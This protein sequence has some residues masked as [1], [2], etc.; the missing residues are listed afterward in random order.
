MAN[1]QKENGYVSIANELQ[2]QFFRFSF[3]KRQH[4][5]LALLLRLSYGC[6][7]KNCYIPALAHF[8]ICG[9]FKQDI[10]KEID[11]LI[12]ARVITWNQE[13]MIFAINKDYEEWTIKKNDKFDGDILWDLVALQLNPDYKPG[14]KVS[15]TL[16]QK[17]PPEV[18]K[19]LTQNDEG[20]QNTYPEVSKTLTQE[21][22]KHLPQAPAIPWESKAETAPKDNIKDN[23]KTINNITKAAGF[24][25][26]DNPGEIFTF[27]DQNIKRLTP[28]YS[29]RINDWLEDHNAELVL[30]V[31]KHALEIT[32]SSG[33]APLVL[34]DKIFKRIREKG[35]ATVSD[36]LAAEEKREQEREQRPPGR[37]NTR[38]EIVPEWFEKAQAERRK[39]EQ[40]DEDDISPEEFEEKRAA[41]L[42]RLNNA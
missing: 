27:F 4:G 29:E 21:L 34:I 3:S 26:K 18:S 42:A 24:K 23:I 9:M 14:K 38:P 25:D 6:N 1:P 10:R 15:K 30:H 40:Q 8:K 7:R 12:A 16:T 19:T 11:S 39:K 5:I 31:F 22:V 36:F 37:K 41:L 13:R 2:E 32:T 20:K 33:A 17:Q 35:I 28:F